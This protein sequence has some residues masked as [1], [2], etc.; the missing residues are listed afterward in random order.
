MEEPTNLALLLTLALVMVVAWLP[1][2]ACQLK[3]LSS[4]SSILQVFMVLVV[5]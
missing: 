5:L 1:E 4:S 3:T 2:L